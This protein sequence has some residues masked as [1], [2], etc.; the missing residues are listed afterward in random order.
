MW[1]TDM[2]KL[3]AL[4]LL[5]ALVGTAYADPP[6]VNPTLLNP[7]ILGP[8]TISA[9]GINASA[10]STPVNFGTNT[11]AVGNTT[12]TGTLSAASKIYADTGDTPSIA[13]GA[14]GTGTNGSITGSDQA[15]KIT[16]GASA[17]TACAVTF[18]STWS[19]APRACT[20][21]AASSG[22]AAVTVL[23]YIS[24]TSA[25]G[26]TLSGAVLASTSFYYQCF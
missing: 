18:G 9:G 4:L 7:T 5:A 1:C 17:T 8:L 26:F 14:C 24:A 19:T 3:L 20:F 23:P 15:G 13:S 6:I 21:S 2:K 12:V 22:A 25:T 11:L 16:I 10:A